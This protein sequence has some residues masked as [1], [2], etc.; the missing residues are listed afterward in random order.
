MNKKNRNILI[1]FCVLLVCL[2]AYFVIINLT[3]DETTKSNENTLVSTR[4][5]S[6]DKDVVLTG[7]SIENSSGTMEFDYNSESA[8]WSYPDDLS[9]PVNNAALNTLA[10]E[11]LTLTYT[12]S[13]S[14]Y[15][16]LSS[17]NL[18][19][20]S[21]IFTIKTSDD[22]NITLLCSDLVGADNSFYF[23]TDTDDTI[24]ITNTN[25]SSYAGLTLNDYFQIVEIPDF[26]TFE[27]SSI[28]FGNLESGKITLT[29]NND[30]VSTAEDQIIWDFVY[31][32]FDTPETLKEQGF[33]ADTD[34]MMN[35]LN[36]FIFNRV[37]IYSATEEELV[38]YG[39]TDKLP[40]VTIN[41]KGY[42]SKEIVL[43]SGA[44]T[45]QLVESE[46][47]YTITIGNPT[48]PKETEYY[49]MVSCVESEND[50]SSYHSNAI[51]EMNSF[52]AEYFMNFT[53]DD[54]NGVNR[55]KDS[56]LN[57][58]DIPV[59]SKDNLISITFSST[60]DILYD[61]FLDFTLDDVGYECSSDSGLI[62]SGSATETAINQLLEYLSSENQM[63]YL[64]R[65]SDSNSDS[66]LK[67]YGLL[68]PIRELSISYEADYINDDGSI[69]TYIIDW[70]L[71]IGMVDD[72]YYVT[73]SNSDSIYTIS[74]SFVNYV[75]AFDEN[76]LNGSEIYGKTEIEGLE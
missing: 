63:D 26:F 27:V 11:I 49:V 33:P 39:F 16:S 8:T 38:K 10:S 76:I 53:V 9:F 24:Y 40:D 3:K 58:E 61:L 25:L 52:Y 23:K 36:D 68:N 65:V 71:S 42:T 12:R 70:K 47:T 55:I 69:D 35:F 48:S 21:I 17:Y 50:N 18:D 75:L 1:V 54:I 34:V 22:K 19:N 4:F 5:L 6:F 66:E 7:L 37:T 2:I 60:T 46:F 57:E 13:I 74:D 41:F 44:S 72:V 28:I 31:E 14:D 51:Y 59:I 30:V 73:A 29:E 45:N 43:D 67:L 32:D 62:S 15:S 64:K 20:P 56:L